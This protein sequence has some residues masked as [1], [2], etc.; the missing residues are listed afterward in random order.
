LMRGESILLTSYTNSAIDNLLM[1]LKAEVCV[2]KFIDVAL[3]HCK[4]L[5]SST[6]QYLTCCFEYSSSMKHTCTSLF[7]INVFL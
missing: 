2:P 1:K 5:I 7:L 6:E 4:P 3:F